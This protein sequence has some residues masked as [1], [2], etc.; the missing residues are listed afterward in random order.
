MGLFYS[1]KNYGRYLNL[2]E[3]SKNLGYK[4]NSEEELQLFRF[5]CDFEELITNTLLNF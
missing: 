2:I 5:S 3:M 4:M 1:Q